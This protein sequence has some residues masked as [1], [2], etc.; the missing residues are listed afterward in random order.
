MGN[1]ALVFALAGAVSLSAFVFVSR[2]ATSEADRNLSTHTF[3]QIAREAALT[4]LNTTVRR[5]V[6]DTNSW[7]I[8]PS[9]YGFTDTEYRNATFTTHVDTTGFVKGPVLD[10]CAIDT[11]RVVSVGSSFGGEDHMVDAVY[12]RTCSSEGAPP[13]FSHAIASDKNFNI[14][15]ETLILSGDAL[16]NA[17]VHT[18][19]Q[20][21]VNGSPVVEGYGT[22]VMPGGLCDTCLG[23]LPNDDENGLN[24]N[25]F[26]SDSVDIPT[27]VPAEIRPQATY[28]EGS[29]HI[30]SDVTIDFTNYQGITGYGTQDNPFIWYIEGDFLLDAGVEMRVEGYVTIVVE[31]AAQINADSKLLASLPPNTDPPVTTWLYPNVLAARD[32]VNEY[33]PTGTTMGLYVAGNKDG[34]PDEP[35][36]II[37]GNT[38]ITGQVFAN[39]D[40]RVNGDATVFGA[41]ATKGEMQF[42]GKNIIW[43]AGANE[44]ILLPGML[45]ALPDGVR[46]LSYVEW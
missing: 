29:V 40:I 39:D 46:L 35:S 7:F 44:G 45:I 21:Y 36:V 34:K 30:N 42:N 17:N 22:Y 2:S 27:F 32:F 15:G 26:Q 28:V 19:R 1:Y 14:N 24:P 33:M 23:F 31:G 16:K 25:V 43:Y 9:K 5:I 12:V 41:M 6:A 3:N 38:V 37:N 8:D 11:V 20:L 13:A 10:R 18:N 4:G